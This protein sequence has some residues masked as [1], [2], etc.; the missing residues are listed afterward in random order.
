MEQCHKVH[1]LMQNKALELA[2]RI[3]DGE[4]LEQHRNI[5]QCLL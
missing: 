2:L 4:T 1:I 5:I 3:V